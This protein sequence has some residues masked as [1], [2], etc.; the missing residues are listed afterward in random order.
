MKS[1][2]ISDARNNLA[3]LVNQVAYGN[4]QIIIKKMGKPLAILINTE[5]FTHKKTVRK[6][7][8]L[9]SLTA[10]TIKAPKSFDITKVF[11]AIKEPYDTKS[12]LGR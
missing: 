11:E 2:S 4:Q 8:K 3:E 6:T 7:G 12:L 9:P 1:V 10:G 5:E